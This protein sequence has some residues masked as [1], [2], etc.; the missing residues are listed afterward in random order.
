MG[1]PQ[2]GLNSKAKITLIIIMLAAGFSVFGFL[3]YQDKMTPKPDNEHWLSVG[4]I[5]ELHMSKK[6]IDF[7][8]YKGSMTFQG[9]SVDKSLEAPKGFVVTKDTLVFK[10]KSDGK[11]E[12]AAVDDLTNGQE[13][14]VWTHFLSDH[15]IGA[16]EITIIN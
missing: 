10:K 11:R 2:R 8:D 6:Q 5:S 7:V 3:Y 1:Y 14:E 13:I 16:Y 12:L 4:S 15:L 9:E